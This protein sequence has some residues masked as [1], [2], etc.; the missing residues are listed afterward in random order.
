MTINF[1]VPFSDLF[2][3]SKRKLDFDFDKY[4]EHWA[5]FKGVAFFEKIYH[6]SSKP[7]YYHTNLS[8]ETIVTIS[9]IRANHYNLN[10]SLFRKT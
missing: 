5:R 6:K 3:I 8:R 4:L 2:F 9:R 10:H 1:K 7:W